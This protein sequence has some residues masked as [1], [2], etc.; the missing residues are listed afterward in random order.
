MW[1]KLSR[2]FNIDTIPIVTINIPKKRNPST[3][4]FEWPQGVYVY[5]VDLEHNYVVP[6]Y[7]PAFKGTKYILKASKLIRTLNPALT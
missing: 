2:E 4:I 3:W 1:H 7:V 5:E 6:T